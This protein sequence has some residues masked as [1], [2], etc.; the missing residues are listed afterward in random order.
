MQKWLADNDVLIYLTRN[1]GNTIVA[2]RFVRTLM[3][4]IYKNESY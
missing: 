3:G 4:K 1:E 2:E